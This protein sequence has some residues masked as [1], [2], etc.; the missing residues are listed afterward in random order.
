ML[1][2]ALAVLGAVIVGFTVYDLVATTISVSRGA[3]PMTGAISRRM[4]QLLRVTVGRHR[5][6]KLRV[7]GALILLTTI[8]AWVTLLIIG[9]SFVFAPTEALVS[10]QN[11]EPVPTLGRTYYAATTI[12]GR[13]GTA[14]RPT[15]DL[16]QAIEELAGA[17]GVMLVS[18]SI[19]WIIP[20][21]QGV[22]FKRTTALTISSL[23]LTP[24]EILQGAWD[25]GDLGD[26]HLHVVALT[27]T[28]AQLAQQHLAYPVIH[29]FH[30]GD[31]RTAIGPSIVALDE[32]LTINERVLDPDVRMPRSATVPLR[33][34]ITHFLETLSDAFLE[35]VG[36]E[37]A[38]GT[39]APR[40]LEGTELPAAEGASADP[41][42]DVA[43]RRRTLRAY[44]RHDGWDDASLLPDHD[45]DTRDGEEPDDP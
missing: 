40:R 28:I 23:G 6:G 10:G 41:V 42:E 36:E 44:L 18:L 43:H 35:P 13:G 16:W 5:P 17:S 38:T 26:L 14:A 33:R 8:S 31:R 34:V 7:G 37:Q 9:W 24:R 27:P 1:S 4:W 20:V 19:A 45:G 2:A 32:V 22:V 21:V 29:Y 15:S 39:P 12:I 25:E 11:E 3:G 30:S